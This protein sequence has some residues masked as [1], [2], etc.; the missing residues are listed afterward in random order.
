VHDQPEVFD[1]DTIDMRGAA[2]ADLRIAEWP[3][4]TSPAWDALSQ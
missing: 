4:P 2:L 1:E 3:G